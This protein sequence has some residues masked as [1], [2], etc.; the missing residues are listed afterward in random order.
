VAVVR[1]QHIDSAVIHGF[2]KAQTQVVKANLVLISGIGQGYRVFCTG[3]L[4]F[5]FEIGNRVRLGNLGAL[6]VRCRRLY[7]RK[8][9]APGNGFHGLPDS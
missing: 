9:R 7:W 4:I 8:D 5:E 2:I 1:Q 3:F 6:P